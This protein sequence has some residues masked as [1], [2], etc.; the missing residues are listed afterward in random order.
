M[1]P[2]ETFNCLHCVYKASDARPCVLGNGLKIL[3]RVGTHFFLEKNIL[4]VLKGI[5]YIYFPENL[6]KFW[7]SPVNLGRV[8]LPPKHRYFFYLAQ[9]QKL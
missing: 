8:G 9:Q 2:P 3:G 5:N 1:T 6:K 4:C 7:V